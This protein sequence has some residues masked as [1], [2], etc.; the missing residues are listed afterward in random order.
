M[1]R[2]NLPEDL[3]EFYTKIYFT[4]KASPELADI[5]EQ[6][7]TTSLNEVNHGTNQ[8]PN[9]PNEHSPVNAKIR[10]DQERGTI[11]NGRSSRTSDVERGRESDARNPQEDNGTRK[12]TTL[13]Q[14]LEATQDGSISVNFSVRSLFNQKP[15]QKLKSNMEI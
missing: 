13:A 6:L 2:R 15:L 4:A 10:S 8:R 9:L 11:D 5:F 1:Y 3:A 7:V 14:G 12:A